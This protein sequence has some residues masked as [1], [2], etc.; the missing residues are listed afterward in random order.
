[1][2]CPFPDCEETVDVD[3]LGLRIFVECEKNHKSC[4]KCKSV[5]WH[6]QKSCDNVK[7]FKNHLDL[8]Q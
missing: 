6:D 1:M 3:P 5:G 8:V 2:N 4:T 7:I